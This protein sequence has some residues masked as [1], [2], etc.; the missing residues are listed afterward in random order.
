MVKSLDEVVQELNRRVERFRKVLPV[1]RGGTGPLK[2]QHERRTTPT[3]PQPLV[4]T[5]E[6]TP[7]IPSEPFTGDV[8]WVETAPHPN[9]KPT[10]PIRG[11]PQE[12]TRVN[13]VEAIAEII[14]NPDIIID[15]R[16]KNLINS[17]TVG[18]DPSTGEI[19]RVEELGMMDTRNRDS[20]DA[21]QFERQNILPRKKRKVS[22]YQKRFGIE[23]KK[24]KKL[25]PRT[26]IQNLMKKAHRR[27]RAAMKKK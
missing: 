6:F 13:A 7:T 11:P 1:F 19:G 21:M 2:P 18:M 26:K 25:H 4:K 23:L 20:I 15:D 9:A 16:L 12:M 8:R 5:F 22:P 27:T 17:P 24:L 14:N 10:K 3:Q